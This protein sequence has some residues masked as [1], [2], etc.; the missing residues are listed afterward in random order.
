M[1]GEVHYY[2]YIYLM[3]AYSFLSSLTNRYFLLR[4]WETA[5]QADVTQS[6][7]QP[8][9]SNSSK[10]FLHMSTCK[11]ILLYSFPQYFCHS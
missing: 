8:A 4:D 11:Q 6:N 10:L 3:L 7:A 1:V 2:K 9:V 5:M